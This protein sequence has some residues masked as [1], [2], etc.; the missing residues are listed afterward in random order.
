M[1]ATRTRGMTAVAVLNLILGAVAT[2]GSMARIAID[3]GLAGS[4]AAGATG[5]VLAFGFARVAVSVLLIV[6]GIGVLRMRPWGRTCAI[7]AGAL[8]ILVNLLEPLLLHKS[9]SGE[10]VWG[11]LYSAILLALFMRPAWARAFQRGGAPA[12]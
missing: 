8:W 6:S 10:F 11:S 7:A 12:A 2:L 3:L 1:A 4:P 5:I 9:M